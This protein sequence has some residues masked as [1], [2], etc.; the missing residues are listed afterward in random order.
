ML[1]VQV[2]TLHTRVFAAAAVLLLLANT[3]AAYVAVGRLIEGDRWVSHTHEVIGALDELVS[4]LRE[5]ETDA[6]TFMLTGDES[7]LA[8]YRA[9]GPL[10]WSKL[11]EIQ[12]LTHDNPLQQERTAELRKLIDHRLAL[13]QSVV[14]VAQKEGFEAARAHTRQGQGK[15]ANAALDAA[16]ANMKSEELRLL[17]ERGVVARRGARNAYLT[18]G[19]ATAFA[20]F[21][22]AGSLRFLRQERHG[23]GKAEEVSARLGWALQSARGGAWDWDLKTRRVWWSP[24]MYQLWGVEHGTEQDRPSSLAMVDQRDRPQLDAAVESAIKDRID[25]RFEFRIQHPRLGERWMTSFARTIYDEGGIPQRMLGV[26]LDITEHKIAEQQVQRGREL[27]EQFVEQAPA[28]LAMFDREMRYILVSDKWRL[29]TAAGTKGLIGDCHYDVFP[30]LP[31]HW[32]QLHQRGLAG[33]TLE[34]EEDWTAL[35]GSV[36]SIRWKIHPWGDEGKDTGGIFIFFEDITERKRVDMERQKFVSL[37]D[38]SSQFIGMCDTDFKPFYANRAALE[39]VGLNSQAEAI[40]T[41]VSDFFFP[42]DRDFIFNDFFPRVLRDGRAEIEIRLRH[43]K[44]GEPVWVIYNVFRVADENG[45]PAGFATVSQNIQKR[46][47]AEQEL[48]S[49]ERKIRAMFDNVAVGMAQLAPD[50]MFVAVNQRF[51]TQIGYTPEELIGKSFR[52]ITHPDDLPGELKLADSLLRGEI[53][54][55]TYEKRYLRKDSGH[56]W[57]GVTRSLVRDEDGQPRYLVGIVED[58]TRRKQAEGASESL[59]DSLTRSEARFRAIYEN[60]SVGIELVAVNGSLLMVNAALCRLLGY[61]QEELRARTFADITNP[62]DLER[63]SV[64]LRELFAGSRDEYGI[65]KRYIRQDGSLVWVHVASRLVRDDRGEP[66]YRISAIQDITDRKH[67]ER[68]MVTAERISA[69]SKLA[70]ALAHEIVN[71]LM[72]IGNVFHL[73]EADPSINTSAKELLALG[74]GELSHVDEITRRALTI[75]RG[76]GQVTSTNLPEMFDGMIELYVAAIRKARVRVEPRYRMAT[77]AVIDTGV[78]KQVFTNLLTNA[79]DAMPD[80]GRLRVHVYTGHAPNNGL[81]EGVHLVVADTGTGIAK[82]HLSRIYDPFFTTKGDRGTGLGLWVVRSMIV[83][84][85]GTV[86]IRSSQTGPRRGTCVSVF[87]PCTFAEQPFPKGENAV[88]AR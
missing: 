63:E 51:A 22:L 1:N 49:S 45:R 6:R 65:D 69:A 31:P 24:E 34:E 15:Q 87:L 48:Q 11:Q 40:S 83:N 70:A 21:F 56:I 26:T 17:D 18:L 60:A 29:D 64:L 23:R 62:E 88:S 7:Y 67:A 74:A 41:N 35:D 16:V 50:G 57:A 81:V 20:L 30:D 80:G 55:Y 82:E 25:G 75:S 42:E 33:E 73:L 47:R 19:I 61:T 86:R 38:N 44:T 59:L 84:A 85:G 4:R 54:S 36:H 58:I 71:S 72:A 76:G 32:K 28:S 68:A 13:L 53:A 66:L 14:D 52:D 12:E 79:L 8:S 37:A 2:R 27:L 5:A 46:K 43:F 78:V 77:N 9:D 39:L 3:F 10:I